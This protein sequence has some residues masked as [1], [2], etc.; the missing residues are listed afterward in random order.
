[1]NFKELEKKEWFKVLVQIPFYLSILVWII[2]LFTG[3]WTIIIG[4]PTIWI[5]LILGYWVVFGKRDLIHAV[6]DFINIIDGPVDKVKE[7]IHCHKIPFINY[8]INI[9]FIMMNRKTTWNIIRKHQKY[10]NCDP[11][12]FPE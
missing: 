1:M 4:L 10:D 8:Q 6:T 11:E 3:T 2:S 9:S 12:D 7:W 5:A